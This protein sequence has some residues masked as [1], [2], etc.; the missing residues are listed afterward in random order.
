M[1]ILHLPN[2]S[3]SGEIKAEK[4]GVACGTNVGEKNCIRSLKGK[5]TGIRL[6]GRPSCR[7]GNINR[8]GGS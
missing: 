2:I 8:L 3:K 7:W 5:P 4:M 1:M 6:F